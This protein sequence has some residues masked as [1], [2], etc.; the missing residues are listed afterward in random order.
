LRSVGAL[1]L[2]FRAV[3][4]VACVAEAGHDV[5]LLVEAVVDGG[6][7]H[8]QRRV[9]AER[10]LHEAAEAVA[11]AKKKGDGSMIRPPGFCEIRDQES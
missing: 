11:R 7:H 2:L 9:R 5:A 10:L 1:K 4:A 6:G 8:V 3:E